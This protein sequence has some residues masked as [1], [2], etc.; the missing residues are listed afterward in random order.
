MRKFTDLSRIKYF[1]IA[2]FLIVMSQYGIFLTQKFLIFSETMFDNKTTVTEQKNNVLTIIELPIVYLVLSWTPCFG[3]YT[4]L[5]PIKHLKCKYQNCEL[6]SNRSLFNVSDAVLFHWRDINVSDL[7]SYH[8][9]NQ[10]W[11]L[12]N[13]ESPNNSPSHVIV[14]LADQINWTMTYRSNSNIYALYG[15]FVNCDNSDETSARV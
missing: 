7:P 12:L 6:T 1:C 8:S 10:T 11:I 2:S 9:A 14:P 15:Q 4:E 3:S 13:Q 5:P